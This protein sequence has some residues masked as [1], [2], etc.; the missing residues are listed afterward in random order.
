MGTFAEKVSYLNDTKLLIKEA[1][2]NKGVTVEED[3][4]FREYA[5]KIANI[6]ASAD[7]IEPLEVTENGT[8]EATAGVGGYNPVIVNVPIGGLPEEAFTITG[9]CQYLF[10]NSNWT[11]F[12]EN[13]GSQLQVQN[14]TSALDMLHNYPLQAEVPFEIYFVDNYSGTFQNFAYKA[15]FTRAP[16]LHVNLSPGYS[17]GFNNMFNDCNFMREIPYDYFYNMT[18]P[19]NWEKIK[20]TTAPRQ[21]IFC[22]CYSLKELPDISILITEVTGYYNGLYYNAF[23]QC[24]ALNKIENIPLS[25]TATYTSNMF[26]GTFNNV[27]RCNKVTF[28]TDNGVPYNVN[29]KNQAIDLHI[30]VGYT[31]DRYYIINYNSGIPADKQIKDYATYQALKDDPDSFATNMAYSRYNHDSAVE[32]INSLPDT[33]AYLAANGG[34]NTIKFRG[35][36]GSATDGGAINTLTEEEIAVATAKGWTVTFA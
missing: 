16:I 34:T 3:T 19:E 7:D 15:K 25:T 8:Y 9:N 27:Y 33:S 29:W 21:G 6:S 2:K 5:N 4:P 12:V 24:Y 14:V 11:W 35:E 10:Y 1:I 20:K 18:T 17:N 26:S 32:T 23:Y 28:M 31:N 36:A 13:Y 22:N 30:S